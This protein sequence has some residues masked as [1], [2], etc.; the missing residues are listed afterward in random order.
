VSNVT[1]IIFASLGASVLTVAGA[2]RYSGAPSSALG[3]VVGPVDWDFS[4][5]WASNLALVGGALGATISAKFFPAKP[6][7]A[8]PG[9]YLELSLLFGV[10]VVVAPFVYVSLQRGTDDAKGVPHLRGRGWSLLVACSITV[11]GVMGQL[12]TLGLAFYEL[13]HAHAFPLAATIPLWVVLGA[14]LVLTARYAAVI[15]RVVVKSTVPQVQG[16]TLVVGNV[17]AAEPWSLL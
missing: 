15:I 1:S 12:G 4:K 10:L 16:L 8:T 3:H 13:K 5:S 6:A 7:I 17:P 2:W 9:D 14:A 11:W